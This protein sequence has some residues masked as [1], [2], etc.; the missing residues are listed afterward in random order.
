MKN[1]IIVFIVTFVVMVLATPFVF[2]KL[3]NSKFNKMLENL[4]KQ[5]YVIKE[6]ENKSSY[7]TTDRVFKVVVPGE[8]IDNSGYIKDIV[9]EVESKFKNLPVTDVKFLGKILKVESIDKAFEE[10]INQIIKDKIRF[11][12]VTPNFKTYKYRLFDTD[13]LAGLNEMKLTGIEGVYDY[14]YKNILK[15]KSLV[16]K[17]VKGIILEIKQFTHKFEEKEN[18]LKNDMKFNFYATL[19]N[20]KVTLLNVKTDSITYL[21]NKIKSISNLQ[22][23]TLNFVN[24]IIIKNFKLNFFADNI[25]GK[26]VKKLQNTNDRFQR[27]QLIKELVSKGMDLKLDLK[28]KDIEAMKQKLGFFDLNS[29]L[30]ILPDPM[31]FDK[32]NKNDLSDLEIFVDLKTTPQISTLLMNVIPQSAFAFALAKKEKGTVELIL[33]V[34]NG[35]IYINGEKIKSN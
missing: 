25:D 34:Q 15:A 27:E 16:Y 2:D 20:Q 12:V 6:I 26:I 22:F 29:K 7:L 4:Q 1:K 33:K 30:K 13:L 11:F 5:G 18:T 17:D 19:N 9:L 10:Q 31:L 8:K 21:G 35:V 32:L 23:D 3:M 28:I 14:P 24:N